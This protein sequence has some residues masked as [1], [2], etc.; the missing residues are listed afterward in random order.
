MNYF[1]QYG[2][3][4]YCAIITDLNVKSC[5]IIYLYKVFIILPYLIICKIPIIPSIDPMECLLSER[6]CANLGF[7]FPYLKFRKCFWNLT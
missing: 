1:I 7:P 2:N 4:L 5:F 6:R 3:I